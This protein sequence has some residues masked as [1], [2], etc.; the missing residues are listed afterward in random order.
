MAALMSGWWY[1]QTW[2]ATGSL[3]GEQLEAAALRGAP[4][5]TTL[6]MLSSI[7]WRAAADFAF[8]T[9]VWVG[10]W[11][12][13][14]VRGW[15]YHLLGWVAAAAA[16]GV[17]VRLF[18]P[19]N[20]QR[21]D[22]LGLAL[23]YLAMLS[24]L[25]YHI[26]M[27]FAATGTGATLSYYLYGVVAAEAVLAAVGL[28]AIAPRRSVAVVAPCLALLLAALDVYG[29]LFYLVPYY[30][31]TIVHSQAGKLETAHIGELLGNA[32]RI[33]GRMAENKAGVLVPG[34]MLFLWMLYLVATVSVVICA[35]WFRPRRQ[36]G[37]ER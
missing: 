36:E 23:A 1:W 30:T 32:G 19:G 20:Y 25:A 29:T 14:T 8:V 27:T 15:M 17:L 37:T 35:F 21:S 24:A 26:V 18:R 3:S 11:S 10:N 28:T 9:H 22:L 31:G 7:H 16:L 12:F 5:S 2:R 34:S 13:L 6:G 4:L 33:L